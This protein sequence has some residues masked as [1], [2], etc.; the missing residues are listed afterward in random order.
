MIIQPGLDQPSVANAIE[1]AR[2]NSL[3]RVNIDLIDTA[4]DPIDI[5]E[6]SVSPGVPSGELELE[7]TD[8]GGNVIYTEPYYPKDI[9]ILEPRIQKSS[10]GKYYIKFGTETGETDAVGAILFNWHSRQNSTPEDRYATQVL[11]VVSPRTLSLLPTLR[12]MIDKVTKPVLPEKYCVIGFTDGMLVM[13]LKSGLAIINQAE[14]YPSFLNVD[15]FPIEL[16]SDILLK[17][18]LYQ[19]LTCQAMFAIDTDV[20]NYADSGH[21]F[22]LQHFDPIM[23][24]ISHLKQELDAAIPNF[25]RKF[26]N[27]GTVSIEMR[28][29]MSFAMLLATAPYGSLFRNLW[30]S[31]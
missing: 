30:S 10:T 6:K 23:R 2:S 28:L 20:P 29:N 4:G 18:A 15:A 22:V 5:E 17:A 9:S 7:V 11:E 8:L 1:L 31:G 13:F 27:S 12:L 26:V 19:G 24:Y 25:K 3:R 16:Y 14:P 21:S